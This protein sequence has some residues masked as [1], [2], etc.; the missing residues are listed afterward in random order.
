MIPTAATKW[1][2]R[3]VVSD[4]QQLSDDGGTE[5][6]PGQQAYEVLIPYLDRGVLAANTT[7]PAQRRISH[8]QHQRPGPT[9][10]SYDHDLL[11]APAFRIKVQVTV[12]K[13][14]F[15]LTSISCPGHRGNP[16]QPPVPI[17]RRPPQQSC[18]PM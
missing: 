15:T 17:N 5:R 4:P 9:R 7:S 18:A 13:C 12:T 10:S 2:L 8:D 3:P 11:K 6:R 14:H 16:A 1:W